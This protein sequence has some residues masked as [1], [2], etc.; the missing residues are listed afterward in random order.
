MDRETQKLLSDL[1]TSLNNFNRTAGLFGKLVDKQ[2]GNTER[3]GGANPPAGPAGGGPSRDDAAEAFGNKAAEAW[4]KTLDM[5]GGSVKK[6]V[7]GFTLLTKNS[8]KASE[9]MTGFAQ[10][11]TNFGVI[12]TLIEQA[13]EATGGLKRSYMELSSSG[14]NFS[15]GL[16][17]LAR[18]AYETGTSLQE[19]TRLNKENSVVAARMNSQGKSFAGL[20]GQVRKNSEAF[21][22]F[23]YSVKDLDDV[24]GTVAE[25]YRVTG[26]AQELGSADS[27]EA[28]MKVAGQADALGQQFGKSRMEIIKTA[29]EAQKDE[30]Y[31]SKMAGMSQAE[32][33]RYGEAYGSAMLSLSAQAGDAGKMLAKML[34]QTA[35][36]D[37]RSMNTE[38]ARNLFNKI[39]PEGTSLMAKLYSDISRDK[40][41]AAR[42]TNQYIRDLKAT[43]NASRQSLE[44]QAEGVGE[45]AALARQML[46]LASELQEQTD[47]QVNHQIEMSKLQKLQKDN[48]T[49]MAVTWEQI[50]MRLSSNV[51]LKFLP[52]VEGP[53][54]AI[55]DGI[56]RF[57]KSESFNALQGKISALGESLTRF[58]NATFSDANM[59]RFSLWISGLLDG[60][61][62]ALNGLTSSNIADGLANFGSAISAVW[63]GLKAVGGFINDFVAPV[64]K[65]M[66]GHMDKVVLALEVFVAAW[67][68]SKL[69]GIF[70]SLAGGITSFLNM[71]RSTTINAKT[72]H[73]NGPVV[74]GG[75]GAAAAGGGGGAGS[76]ASRFA[77]RAGRFAVIAGVVGGVAE[78]LGLL[79]GILGRE[80]R[81]RQEHVEQLQQNTRQE[82]TEADKL[83]DFHRQLYKLYGEQGTIS[84]NQRRALER[85]EGYRRQQA[86][87]RNQ[88]TDQTLAEGSGAEAEAA[89][90][91]LAGV[92]QTPE[93]ARAAGTNPSTGG[94]AGFLS[95]NLPGMETALNQALG[96]A[97]VASIIPKLTGPMMKIIPGLGAIAE[98][99][100]AAS[101]GM[102]WFRGEMD[103]KDFAAKLGAHAVDAVASF[104]PGVAQA[105]AGAS[106][107]GT[108]IGDV[109]S[110]YIADKI[111]VSPTSPNAPRSQATPVETQISNLRSQ[112]DEL[113]RRLSAIGPNQQ[114]NAQERENLT[115]E[116]RKTN[117]LLEQ[118]LAAQRTAADANNRIGQSMVSAVQNSM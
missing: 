98:G 32:A 20:A 8:D 44:I 84:D 86:N 100:G 25:T 62:T 40:A 75:R 109:V 118:Q 97:G 87:Q 46:A 57:S 104:I 2:R 9:A 91:R 6:T 76:R 67:V 12:G 83:D 1:T 81:T 71:F 5:I 52:M 95:S 11:L 105:N 56:D 92:E 31:R 45:N 23:N 89:R 112:R 82:F 10:R 108:S 18:K 99:V 102:K 61:A 51:L 30:V 117:A 35:A 77:G 33:A 26:R 17:D 7:T 14:A 111:N 13:V 27:V 72:V 113:Q 24:V 65:A 64:L 4:D 74:G 60:T 96:L 15:D 114:Q 63:S 93:P 59:N 28:M 79:D 110:R 37:G 47:E 3:S 55:A 73:V 107:I 85:D 94:V 116:I 68:A 88:A 41:N 103:G 39:L 66:A 21:G 80:N 69:V 42:Y 115:E 34:A 78:Q 43:V 16:F 48:L 106:I 101:D 70:S 50:W 19:Y 36:F 58:I 53:M 22:M 90:R 38:A 29:A 49:K 54:K